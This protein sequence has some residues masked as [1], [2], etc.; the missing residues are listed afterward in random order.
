MGAYEQGQKAA[1][2]GKSGV[3]PKG[4]SQREADQYRQGFRNQQSKNGKK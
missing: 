3:P 4:M 1:N 2:N